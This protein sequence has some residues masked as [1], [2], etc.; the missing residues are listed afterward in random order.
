MKFNKDGLIPVIVQ[1]Y[2]TKKVLMLAYMNEEAFEKTVKTKRATFFSR[3]RKKIWIKGE[4][5]GNFQ[6][7][8]EIQI[9]CD[10]DTLLILVK[11]KGP[12]CHEGYESC[13]F[14]KYENGKWIIFEEK[15]FEPDEVYKKNR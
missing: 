2:D 13:F 3:S 9:D 14:R 4:E 8:V 12:A 10:E 1:D 11:P 6:E 15:K 7:V 5:S